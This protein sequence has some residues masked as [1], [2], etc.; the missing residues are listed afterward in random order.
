L[1]FSLSTNICLFGADSSPPAQSIPPVG[2]QLASKLISSTKNKNKDKCA[3]EDQAFLSTLAV[4]LLEL[5]YQPESERTRHLEIVIACYVAFLDVVDG[6]CEFLVFH[7][8]LLLRGF[9]ID[10]VLGSIESPR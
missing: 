6:D 5:G 9:F 1:S 8:L 4:L 7:F 3:V 2:L 10:V